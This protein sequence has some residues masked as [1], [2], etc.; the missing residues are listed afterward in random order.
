MYGVRLAWSALPEQVRGWVEE[1]LG[2]PV[3]EAVTQPAGF[4]PGSADRVRTADGSRAFVKAVSA[5]QNPDT[6]DL[7]RRE[8]SV[9]RTLA[10]EASVPRLIDGYDD[11]HWVALVIEDVEGRHPALPWTD[12]ELERTLATLADLSV[13]AAPGSWPALEEELV[14]EF[15]CW[16]RVI[17]EP[18]PELPDAAPED[19]GHWLRDVPRQHRLHAAAQ[20]TLPRLAGR[21]VAHTDLRADNLLIDADGTVR[22]V[23][24]PWAS[25][26]AAWFDAVS[27]LVNVRWSGD[28]DVR[29]HLPAVHA[30]GATEADVTGTLAGLGGFCVDAARR[31]PKPGLPTLRDF[32]AAQARAALT[33]L[34]EL[35]LD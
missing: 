23:D 27:L 8:I 16:Q 1:T 9:L 7:H 28:L 13:V 2:S 30:L 31:P 11:G 29:P 10:G 6:P 24:W 5:K 3:V 22:V 19:I 15:G 4:S 17:D 18:L 25:R 33:L 12:V 34:R 35:G 20:A 32:Q 21:A 14:G 26:G